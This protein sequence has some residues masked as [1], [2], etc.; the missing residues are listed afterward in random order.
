[1]VTKIAITLSWQVEMQ[2]PAN[3]SKI[4]SMKEINKWTIINVSTKEIGE[5]KITNK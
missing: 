4:Q 1:L 2:L 5:E 3:L